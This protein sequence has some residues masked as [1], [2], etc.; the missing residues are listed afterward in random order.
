[1]RVTPMTIKYSVPFN[2]DHVSIASQ[3]AKK[4]KMTTVV[5]QQAL[6]PIL[7]QFVAPL[8]SV[9]VHPC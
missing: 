8:A 4:L 5:L 1:M 2:I 9:P 6:V 3:R 7:G